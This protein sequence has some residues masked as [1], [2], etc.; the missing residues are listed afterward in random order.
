MSVRDQIIAKLTA[1]LAPKQLEVIDNSAQH[2]A[3]M[4]HPG[5]GT[6]ETHFHVHV[7]S[8][9]FDGV[10]RV[11]RNRMIYD[12]LAAELAGGVHALSMATLT[13]SEALTAPA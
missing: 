3:H 13:P 5:H 12:L 4:G 6:G 8:D 11:A 2:A 9:A 7:V 10:N 1:A